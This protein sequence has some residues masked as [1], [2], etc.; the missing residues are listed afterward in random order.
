MRSPCDNLCLNEIIFP[1]ISF[2]TPELQLLLT[3]LK[4]LCINPNDNTFERSFLLGGLVHTLALGGLHSVSTSEIFKADDNT[5]L[6]D[7]DVAS[8]YPS[9]IIENGL[10]PAHLGPIFT[11]VYKKIKDDRIEAKR[12]GN[13]LKNETYKL[14]I[15]GLTGNLQ[16]EYS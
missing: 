3:E 14:A 9:I 4:S 12:N 15:N 2:N 7:Q 11:E 1:Y 8:L 13:K 16:S 5:I 6:I 10:Y